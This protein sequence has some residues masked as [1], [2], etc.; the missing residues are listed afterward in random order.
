M[1]VKVPKA[2]ADKAIRTT[3]GIY[4]CHG[5]RNYIMMT[6]PRIR[7]L[8]YLFTNKP[9]G[10]VIALSRRSEHLALAK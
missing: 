8:H 10:R 7:D 9:G 5:E 2:E 3:K 6:F 4:E 1:I